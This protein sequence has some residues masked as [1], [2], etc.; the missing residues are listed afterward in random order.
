M[1]TLQEAVVRHGPGYIRRFGAQMPKQYLPLAG[2]PLIR[3]ALATLCAHPRIDRVVVVLA[4]EDLY[5]QG[6]D[7]SALGPKLMPVH[8]GGPSRA[9]SVRRNST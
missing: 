2:Q 4:P 9:V 1:P 6:F 7:W 8:C 3:H 5:W